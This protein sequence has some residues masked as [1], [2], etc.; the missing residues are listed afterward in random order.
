ML[1]PSV[2]PCIELMGALG[3]GLVPPVPPPPPPPLLAMPT[4]E[5]MVG[6]VGEKGLPGTRGLGTSPGL[7]RC[8]GDMNCGGV[9]PGLFMGELLR[10]KVWLLFWGPACPWLKATLAPI[11]FPGEHPKLVW[12]VLELLLWR[13]A[14]G[15][16]FT[17]VANMLPLEGGMEGG[18][19][20]PCPGEMLGF[21]EGLTR[22][23]DIAELVFSWGESMP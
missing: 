6:M 1:G 21:S 2:S 9:I 23:R 22:G 20:M 3:K 19:A 14:P 15:C 4:G 12:L 5:C 18:K 7:T 17:L 11:W 10:F 13:P 16:W 8:L